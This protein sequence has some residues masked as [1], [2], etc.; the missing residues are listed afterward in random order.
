MEKTKHPFS[1]FSLKKVFLTSDVALGNLV[2]FDELS[3][4][5]VGSIWLELGCLT[6]ILDRDAN[7]LPNTR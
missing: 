1:T 6:V 3:F 2:Y 5:F 7:H 4:L